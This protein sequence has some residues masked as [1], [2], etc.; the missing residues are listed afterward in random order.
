MVYRPLKPVAIAAT[1]QDPS[2]INIGLWTN[3]FVTGQLPNVNVYEIYHMV[4]LG[5]PPLAN[6]SIVVGGKAWSFVELS[7]NGGNE[8]DPAEP[9]YMRQDFELYFYWTTAVAPAPTVTIWPRFDD[10]LPENK[11]VG[12]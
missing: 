3:P 8:W 12:R 2:G 1:L 9:L 5:G 11:F 10:A 6:A 7:I 4:V